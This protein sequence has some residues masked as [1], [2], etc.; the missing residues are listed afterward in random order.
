VT[1]RKLAVP[2]MTTTVLTMTLTGLAGDSR[3]AGGD[4]SG[5][6]RRT[7]AV[8]AMLIGALVGA[9]LLKTSLWLVIV[10]ACAAAVV[11]FLAYRSQPG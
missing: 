1:V 10:V 5:T 3:L 6:V 11:T 8:L 9:L 7:A 4:G 2:D